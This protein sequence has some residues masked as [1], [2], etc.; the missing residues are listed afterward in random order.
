MPPV[1]E[2]VSATQPATAVVTTIAYAADPTQTLQIRSANG[3]PAAFIYAVWSQTGAACDSTIHSPRMHDNV[4]GLKWRTQSAVNSPGIMEGLWQPMY[5]Q[6]TP[7]VAATFAAAPNA[8]ENL[9]YGLY[10][11]DLPGS[12]PLLATYAQVMAQAKQWWT[13]NGGYLGVRVSPVT[14]ATAG[15]LGAGVALNSTDSNFKANSWYALLGYQASVIANTILVQGT[16]TGNLKVG[17]PGALA[18]IETRRWFV[19]LDNI[20]GVPSIP[21]FNSANAGST[22]V[23]ANDIA[24]GTTIPVDLT[25]LYLGPSAAGLPF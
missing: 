15:Q 21:V 22:L 23:F 25:F 13:P 2:T 18:N 6:D 3:S 24:G 19:H 1:F 17:G 4:A 14:S 12:A 11:P 10:Y 16:D 5:S 20:L 9:A 7:T 8:V